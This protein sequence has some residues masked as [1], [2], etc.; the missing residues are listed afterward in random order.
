M[1]IDFDDLTVFTK[2]NYVT[3][4]KLKKLNN[5]N[6]KHVS[7]LILKISFLTLFGCAL[8]ITLIIN[9]IYG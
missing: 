4:T 3:T 8:K 9:P 6:V 2:Q 7:H 5:K 1:T